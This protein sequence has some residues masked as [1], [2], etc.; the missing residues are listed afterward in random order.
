[1]ADS[2]RAKVADLF[3]RAAEELR[4][5]ASHLDL[6]ANHFQ[7]DAAA[8]GCAHAFAARGHQADAESAIAEAASIHKKFARL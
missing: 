8:P 1:M 5:A 7:S 3:T 2:D 6:A 4:L